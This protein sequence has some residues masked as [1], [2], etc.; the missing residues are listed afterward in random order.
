[1]IEFNSLSDVLSKVVEE[2]NRFR[3]PEAIASIIELKNNCFVISF[4]GNF[5]FTCGFY[6]WFEDFRLIL[7]DYGLK[8]EISEI[9]QVDI[10]G[11]HV[12]FTLNLNQ[13][14][15]F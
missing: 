12:K 15:Q 4:K 5:C 14:L 8:T 9:N 3:S 7:E 11:F 10:D 13:L 2:Y 6:D 1:M